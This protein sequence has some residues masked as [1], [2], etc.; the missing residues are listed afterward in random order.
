MRFFFCTLLFTLLMGTSAA[1]MVNEVMYNPAGA[2]NNKEF[3]EIFSYPPND[4]SN[5]IISDG[6]SNDTLVIFY[7]NGNSNYSLIV[8]DDFLIKTNNIS[9]YK[10]GATIGNGLSS[11]DV[12]SFYSPNGNL[13]D[14]VEINS[15]IANGNG[16]SMSY[17][18]GSWFESQQINGTPGYENSIKQDAGPGEEETRNIILEIYLDEIIYINTKYTQLF[19]IT[20]ENKA[21][22]SETDKITVSYNITNPELIKQDEFTKEM[23]C[24]SYASTGEFTPTIPGN[25]TICGTIV[26]ST[27]NETDF[28]D[29]W[30]C[31]SFTVIDTSA[32]RCNITINITTNETWVYEEGQS[33]Q[34]E[35]ILNNETFPF[36]IQY[37]IEDFFGNIYKDPYNTTNTN[38]KSWKTNIEEQDRVL[39]IK[40]IVY[41]NC[42]DSYLSDNSAEKM[43]IVKSDY[44]GV[45]DDS[46]ESILDI[47]EVDGN[48]KFGEAIGVKVYIYKGETSKYSIS[49]WAEDNGKK[50]SETTKIHMYDKYS[51]YHGQLPIKLDSNCDKKLK[52]GKYDVIIEGLDKEDKEKIEID[53]IKSSACL[54]SSTETSSS[55]TQSEKFNFELKDFN[56]NIETGKKFNTQVVFDNNNDVDM[57]IKIWSYI[58]RGSKSYSGD[59]EENKK[60]FVLKANSLQVTELSNIVQEAEPGDYKFKVVVNKNNQKT[61]DELT[62]DIAVIDNLNKN[63]IKTK[64][65]GVENI[66][67]NNPLETEIKNQIANNALIGNYN[68]VYESTTEKAK[69]LAP[70]FLIILSVLLNIVLIWRR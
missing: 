11:D 37:W 17:Y 47:V 63:N 7:S 61:N 34:F 54:E 59:R 40:S 21:N 50:I 27:V 33:I 15:S 1:I 48:A 64:S 53:W 41:P 2:D 39:F 9:I 28:S 35:T 26:S 42:N 22:C 32:M 29:N 10:V 70:I 31:T 13:I 56:A 60:E 65:I 49:L 12:I 68:L 36:I 51:S 46:K 25:Y 4:M 16:Y 14:S 45:I 30:A 62:E 43:F 18:N 52:Y 23:G 20:I 8:E 38:Q 19:K 3:I 55:S 6:D 58:Y 24:S 69:N 66:N 44:N 5:Y 57:D 67:E